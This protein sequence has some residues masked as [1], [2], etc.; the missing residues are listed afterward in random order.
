M[1]KI[2]VLGSTG[3]LGSALT[4]VLEKQFQYIYEFNR[5]GVSATGKNEARTIEVTETNEVSSCLNG[6]QI[7]YIINCI[8]MIKHLINEEDQKSIKL[9][10]QINSD[11]PRYLN[12]LARRLEIPV[13]QVGTDCVFSGKSGSYSENDRHD[14]TDI[15]GLTKDKG[16]D[17]AR[18]SMVIRCSIIGREL[19]SRNSL[20]EWVLSQPLEARINGFSNHIWNGVTTLHFSQIIAGI[21]HSGTYKPG[22]LH[23]VPADKVS[24]YE[25]INLISTYFERKDLQINQFEAEIPINRSL[26][27]GNP[28]RNLRIWRDGGY[29]QIP[30]IEEM[31]STYAKWHQGINLSSS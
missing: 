20:L 9:A 10:H 7:D 1:I 22:I 31:V 19:K 18:D 13:I 24:K 8:G 27:S 26:T 21:I 2:A 14:P 29:N 15:Y 5:S 11:F 17:N 28:E 4:Q 25:L 3:M 16:E 23:L 12:D 6:L 30:T